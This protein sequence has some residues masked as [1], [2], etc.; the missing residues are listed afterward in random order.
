MRMLM[1]LE[2]PFPPDIRVENEA[3]ALIEAGHEVHLLCK[4]DQR[5]SVQLPGVLDGLVLH[6]LPE[7][8]SV[9]AR[10]RR[11]LMN[12][13][14][15]WFINVYWLHEIKSLDRR[16]GGFDV[17]HV[18]DLPLVRTALWAARGDRSRVVADLHENYPMAL[19]YYLKYRHRGRPLGWRKRFRFSLRRW[20]RYERKS[21]PSCTAVIAVVEEMKARLVAVGVPHEKIAVVENYV[22]VDRFLSYPIDSSLR[23][24]FRDRMV[25]TYAGVLGPTRGLDMAVRA[26]EHVVREMPT[27]VLLLVG[28]GPIKDE[29]E[30]LS[31]ELGLVE[32]VR[33]EGR[34]PFEHVPSY[35]ALSD[36]CVLPLIKTVQTDAGLAHKLFQY[37]LLG[38]PVVASD[39]DAT[40]RV[41][42]RCAVRAARCSR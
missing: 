4:G 28:A 5:G 12:L 8:S 14:V 25:F 20:R 36:V 16:V 23:A 19:P 33:F 37:M 22:D 10:W 29:L 7:S 3:I 6:T 1:L 26:M 41:I 30:R 31:A 11:H 38:K 18:H 34:V 2:A 15:Y 32:H 40:H 39:C 35:V 13:P 21:V 17:I 42:D 27:A 9:R 24:A